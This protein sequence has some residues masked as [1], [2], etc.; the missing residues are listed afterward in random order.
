MLFC[1]DLF[2]LL[3]MV[4]PTKAMNATFELLPFFGVHFSK[5]ELVNA[6]E[7]FPKE[8]N[9]YNDVFGSLLKKQVENGQREINQ[10]NTRGTFTEGKSLLEVFQI[11]HGCLEEYQAHFFSE[12]SDKSFHQY[13]L[14]A[15]FFTFKYTYLCLD[16]TFATKFPCRTLIADSKTLC[17]NIMATLN[18]DSSSVKI[19]DSALALK[20]SVYQEIIKTVESLL[21]NYK[22]IPIRGLDTTLL[23][24]LVEQAASKYTAAGGYDSIHASDLPGAISAQDISISMSSLSSINGD[25]N[26]N[27]SDYF[28]CE[29][30]RPSQS[31]VQW[32][33]ACICS[34]ACNKKKASYNF[35]WLLIFRL[36]IRYGGED[37]DLTKLHLGVGVYLACYMSCVAWIPLQELVP[38]FF[39]IVL[40]TSY[41]DKPHAVKQVH[42]KL[43]NKPEEVVDVVDVSHSSSVEDKPVF[44]TK[45]QLAATYRNH[46]CFSRIASSIFHEQHTVDKIMGILRIR[47]ADKPNG[48]SALTLKDHGL[49]ADSRTTSLVHS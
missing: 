14:L 42:L 13:F 20:E 44:P 28:P 3:R 6:L 46:A 2:L 39:C 36:S 7:G 38:A 30:K 21:D 37:I 32:L 27:Q 45:R 5:R 29:S 47:A 31:T 34:C 25:K 10:Y 1:Y 22:M 26:P 9:W 40:A 15:T 35:D 16:S 8:D 17:S 11:Y 23:T 43:A 12:E 19:E 48:A 18:G 4:M 49:D 24:Q 41:V 33:L